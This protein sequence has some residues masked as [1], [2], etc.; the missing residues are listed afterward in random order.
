MFPKAGDFGIK[1]TVK[2][3]VDMDIFT[4]FSDSEIFA[5][6]KIDQ[7]GSGF[8]I[9]TNIPFERIFST[10]LLGIGNV[11]GSEVIVIGKETEVVAKVF[12]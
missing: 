10:S 11:E 12:Y 7:S 1:E 4:S 6:S 2:M 9:S 3:M 5:A 8:F